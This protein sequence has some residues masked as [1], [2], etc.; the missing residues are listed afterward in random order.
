[1]VK[2]RIDLVQLVKTL[3]LHQRFIIVVLVILSCIFADILA[4]CQLFINLIR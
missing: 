4:L 2:K 1:M 3:P